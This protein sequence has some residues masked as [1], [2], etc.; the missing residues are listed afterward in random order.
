ME[1]LCGKDD[2]KYCEMHPLAFTHNKVV[3]L[4]FQIEMLK[5]RLEMAQ[6]QLGRLKSRQSDSGILE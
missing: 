2:S 5:A 3:S 6:E 4:H 1:C